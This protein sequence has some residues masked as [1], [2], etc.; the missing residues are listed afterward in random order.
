[1]HREID[2]TAK[3]RR[4]IFL[5]QPKSLSHVAETHRTVLN[6]LAEAPKEPILVGEVLPSRP[7]VEG[8]V[9]ARPVCMHLEI[10]H[11]SSLPSDT[12]EAYDAHARARLIASSIA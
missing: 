4:R 11:L 8:L 3:D 1:M 9:C 6:D 5:G 10:C 7:R 12:S 2:F